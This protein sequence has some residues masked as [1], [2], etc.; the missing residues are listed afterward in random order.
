MIIIT[1][2]AFLFTGYITFA[3]FQLADYANDIGFAIIGGLLGV[4]ITQLA[5]V[6]NR[7]KEIQKQNN[8]R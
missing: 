1:V 5:F 7:L 6:L 3:I 4:V 8:D 2:L